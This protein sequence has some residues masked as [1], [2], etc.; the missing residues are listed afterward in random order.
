[1]LKDTPKEILELQN[2]MWLEKT[3][4]DRAESVFGM[5]AT[6]RKM[7]IST[8]SENLSERE[9]KKQIYE[10]TYGEPLPEDFFDSK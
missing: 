2:K 5:F 6:A 3:P 1:M 4:E 9:F 7:L 8:L 10:R